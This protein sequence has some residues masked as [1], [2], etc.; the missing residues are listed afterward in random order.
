MMRRIRLPVRRVVLVLAL[1]LFWLLATLPL[2]LGMQLFGLAERGLNARSASGSVWSGQLQDARLG[3]L[4]LGSPHVGLSLPRLLTGDARLS[5]G[6]DPDGGISGTLSGNSRG[7]ALRDLNGSAP[8]SAFLPG[9]TG[10]VTLSGVTAIFTDGQCIEAA[11]TLSAAGLGSASLGCTGDSARAQLSGVAE[12]VLGADGE[13]RIS[14][15]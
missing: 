4:P 10:D 6:A 2:G 7:Y 8:M 3:A 11:G 5:L 12:L 9:E 13:L 1:A 14:P 15:L